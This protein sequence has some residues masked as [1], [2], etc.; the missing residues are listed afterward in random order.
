MKGLIRSRELRQILKLPEKNPFPNP[1]RN[2][3]EHI[4]ERLSNWLPEQSDDIPWGWSLST[5]TREY[6][7]RGILSRGT[8][9]LL[10]LV[11]PRI[12]IKC[13]LRGVSIIED[14]DKIMGA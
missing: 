11:R 7:L 9:E 8:M 13:R 2:S 3:F 6:A 10:A 1:V 4:D 14:G 5:H 12:T